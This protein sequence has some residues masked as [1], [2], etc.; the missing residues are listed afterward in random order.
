MKISDLSSHDSLLILFKRKNFLITNSI[1]SV[2]FSRY[3][4]RCIRINF[5]RNFP[6]I[7]EFSQSGDNIFQDIL[8]ESF[9]LLSLFLLESLSNLDR[10]SKRKE[11]VSG[12]GALLALLDG[13]MLCLKRPSTFSPRMYAKFLDKERDRN[14]DDDDG[15]SDVCLIER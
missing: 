1:Q 14:D 3:F 4:F 11:R 12:N 10:C 15:K 8:F 2:C 7:N 13:R 6:K 9:F 5:T